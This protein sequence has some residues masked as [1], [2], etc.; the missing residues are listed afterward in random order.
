MTIIVRHVD[1][2]PLIINELYNIPSHNFCYFT[3]PKDNELSHPY[4][5]KEKQA[6]LVMES[7]LSFALDGSLEKDID[8]VFCEALG[9]GIV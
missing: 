8:S 4:V 3:P 5:Q 2:D 9:S 1:I 6:L 7:L